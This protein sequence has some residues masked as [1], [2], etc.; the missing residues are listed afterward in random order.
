MR[1][2]AHY[3]EIQPGARLARYVECYWLREDSIGTPAHSVLP[4]GCVDI[5]FTARNGEPTDLTIVGLMTKPQSFDIPSGQSYFGVRFRPGMASAFVPEA[6]RLN[7]KVEP[8]ESALGADARRLFEQIGDTGSPKEM[9]ETVE[10]FLRPLEPPDRAHRALDHLSAC[11]LSVDRL[12][13]ESGISVRQLRR[14]CLQ[15]AG[16]SPKYLSRILRFRRAAEHIAKAA[17]QT[18]PVSWAE[19]AA[20]CGYFDQA[21][22]IRE[23]QEFTGSTP[24]RYLQSLP[25][26]SL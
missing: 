9:V 11:D 1:S 2:V 20:A 22:F 17:N 5:L 19:V 26:R 23:F 3:Q 14:A 24:G 18:N 7:D 13:T 25:N 15:R 21:H 16:V 10:R 4:D 8:L 12:A 6:S